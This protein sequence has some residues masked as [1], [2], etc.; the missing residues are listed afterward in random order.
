[1]TN[2]WTEYIRPVHARRVN[3]IAKGS[4]FESAWL[5]RPREIIIVCSYIGISAFTFMDDK[6]C[7]L[8]L[9]MG[10]SVS[11]RQNLLFDTSLP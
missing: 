9:A 6:F 3:Y 5:A 8:N 11:L 2:L 4:G 10:Q 7:Y 1:M